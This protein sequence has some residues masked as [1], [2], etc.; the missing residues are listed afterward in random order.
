[1][2]FSLTLEDLG[3]NMYKITVIEDD[4]KIREELKR[5]LQNNGY[6]VNLITNFEKVEKQI[7]ELESHLILLD[8][9]LPNENGY[10]IC[11]KIRQKSK[12]PIIFVT[13]KNSAMDELNGILQGRR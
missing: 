6:E 5:L 11:S 4:P 13:S 12:L 9:N 3:G 7:L 1:M 2:I 10:E 8:V